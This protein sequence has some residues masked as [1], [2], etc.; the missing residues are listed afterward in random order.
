MIYTSIEQ[1]KKLVELGINTDTADLFWLK[2]F[3]GN[4]EPELRINVIESTLTKNWY[5]HAWSLSALFDI[6]P[7]EFVEEGKFGKFIYELKIRKY[8]LKLS[9][10]N[11]LMYKNSLN[12][13]NNINSDTHS[14][15][16]KRKAKKTMT[17][18]LGNKLKKNKYIRNSLNKKLKQIISFFDFK[19]DN[20]KDSSP[21]KKSRH[22]NHSAG[23][24]TKNKERK[25][26]FNSL[27][28][29]MKKH[30]S[31]NNINISNFRTMRTRSIKMIRRNSQGEIDEVIL[32]GCTK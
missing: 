18:G 31:F 16:F 24:Y 10:N 17:I 27:N 19:D 25:K 8:K 30:L 3:D 9:L 14:N 7:S 28:S 21:I 22:V 4:W 11:M 23:K 1:S 6:I 29:P 20:I 26:S 2:D 32:L 15:L 12:N 5:L 13:N